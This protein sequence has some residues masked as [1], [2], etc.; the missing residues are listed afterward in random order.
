MWNF[1]GD[2]TE[3]PPGTYYYDSGKTVNHYWH[4][5]DQVLIRPEIRANLRYDTLRIVDHDGE[6]SLV[7]EGGRPDR[8]KSDH[9]PITFILELDAEIP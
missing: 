8:D 1:L 4:M 6:E 5:F 7:T 2:E 3:H 9:L